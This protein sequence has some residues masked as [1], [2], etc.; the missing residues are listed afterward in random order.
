[1]G[2]ISNKTLALLVAIAIIVSLVGI[3]SVGRLGV[4]YITGR[5]PGTTG[6]GNVSVTLATEV[7]ILM[8]DSTINFGSGRVNASSN[9]ATLDSAV[10]YSESSTKWINTSAPWTAPDVITIENDGTVTENV[11]VYA[12]ALASGF[13]GGTNPSFQLDN[14]AGN[15]TGEGEFTTYAEVTGT[16]TSTAQLICSGLPYGAGTDRFDI[17]AKIR[18]PSD[19]SVGSKNVTLTFT[20][21]QS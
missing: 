19:A 6:S 12:S 8:V 20:A 2:D 7:S 17:T 4:V 3:L 1:M 11:T 14:Y 18:I 15:C 10:A 9:N 16:N 13:I 5:A 21:L